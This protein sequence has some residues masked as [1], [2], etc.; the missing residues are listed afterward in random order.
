M[1]NFGVALYKAKL[2][3]KDISKIK[4]VAILKRFRKVEKDTKVEFREDLD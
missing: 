4:I 1:N 3:K 2:T